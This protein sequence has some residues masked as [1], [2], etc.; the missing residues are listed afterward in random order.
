MADSELEDLERD[1]FDIVSRDTQV[2]HSVMLHPTL[3]EN[4][5]SHA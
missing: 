1:F 2:R 3:A 5:L 4:Y